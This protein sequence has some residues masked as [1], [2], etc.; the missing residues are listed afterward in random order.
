MFHVVV[1][2]RISVQVRRVTDVVGGEDVQG[3]SSFSN[4]LSV[5]FI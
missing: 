5:L 2:V 3:K 1:G 4:R